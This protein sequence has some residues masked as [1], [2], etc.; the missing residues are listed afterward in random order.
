MPC[1]ICAPFCELSGAP[2]ENWR[3]LSRQNEV[4]ET[5]CSLF[6]IHRRLPKL[7]VNPLGLA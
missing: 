7:D 1:S 3:I 2:S 4:Q 5:Q 6:P